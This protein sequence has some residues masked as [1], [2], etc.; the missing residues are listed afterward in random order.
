MFLFLLA[1]SEESLQHLLHWFAAACDQARMKITIRK[2]E[3]LCLYRS[4][5]N[6]TTSQEVQFVGKLWTI[7]RE[8]VFC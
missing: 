3:V 2:T 6:V 7:C 1:S 4:Q 5:G 8:M